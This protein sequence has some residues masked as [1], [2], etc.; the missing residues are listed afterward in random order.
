MKDY[1]GQPVAVVFDAKG[2]TFRDDIYPSTRPTA[3]PC[4]TSCANR[5]SRSTPSCAP[6]VCRCWCEPGVEADDVIGTLARQASEDGRQVVVSTGDKDMAQLVNEHVT[7]VNTMTETVLTPAGV[8]EK[9]GVPP[10][11]IIDLPGPDGRQGRQHPRGA[12]VGEKTALAL[13][14]GSAVSTRST[15]NLDKVETSASAAPNPW[16][17]A[18]GGA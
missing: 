4:P 14:Q 18:G 10:E 9:F 15:P 11:L 12:G 2:K 3:R 6:W 1:P 7:L 13:L 17:Q 5:S 8:R 16:R